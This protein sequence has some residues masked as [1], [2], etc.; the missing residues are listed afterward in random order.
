MATRQQFHAMTAAQARKAHERKQ[1]ADR[2]NT[3]L[4]AANMAT[5]IYDITRREQSFVFEEDELG[6]QHENEDNDENNNNKIDTNTELPDPP[7]MLD[8]QFRYHIRAKEWR[9]ECRVLQR[10][11][12]N[13]R[14]ARD[15]EANLLHFSENRYAELLRKKE[16]VDHALED[17]QEALQRLKEDL[18]EVHEEIEKESRAKM[19]AVAKRNALIKMAEKTVGASDNLQLIVDSSKV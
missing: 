17:Q 13:A 8:D 1:R 7:F 16:R 18:R 2:A 10:R 14:K 19:V 11:L 9:A 15:R 3:L 6:R 4:H 5:G 12:I